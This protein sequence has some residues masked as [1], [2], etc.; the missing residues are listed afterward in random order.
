MTGFA[1]K[2]YC[3]STVPEASV[4]LRSSLDVFVSIPFTSFLDTASSTIL[5]LS[6]S[7]R[8][9]IFPACSAVGPL[10]TQT[11]LTVDDAV[12]LTTSI[13]LV[14]ASAWAIKAVRRA[15]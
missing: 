12:I 2:D 1:F 5:Y 9:F 6:G 8:E 10:T 7:Q 11:G 3:F 14:W 4:A 13:V 15:L